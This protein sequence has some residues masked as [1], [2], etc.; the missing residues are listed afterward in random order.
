[1]G[2]EW[3]ILAAESC[4]NCG[5]NLEVL[6][7]SPESNDTEFE[8]YFTDGEEVRCCAECGFKSAI[9]VDDGEAWVQDGNIDELS[10][11]E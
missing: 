9:S 7:D 6:S 11:D 5:D 3:K 8:Q 10:D 1:M 4:P 2:K